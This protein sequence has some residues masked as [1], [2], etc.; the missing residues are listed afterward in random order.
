MPSWRDKMTAEDHEQN[1]RDVRRQW[2]EDAQMARS[3]ERQWRQEAERLE[4]LC[5]KSGQD[6]G[7]QCLTY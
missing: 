6:G 5:R 7:A 2:A 4:R 1:W 3:M